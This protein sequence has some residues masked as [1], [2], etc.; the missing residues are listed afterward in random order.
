MGNQQGRGLPWAD[1]GSGLLWH[2][3]CP[4][5]LPGLCSQRSLRPHRPLPQLCLTSPSRAAPVSSGGLPSSQCRPS[6]SCALRNGSCPCHPTRGLT[7]SRSGGERGR[8]HAGA[9][10]AQPCLP[11]PLLSPPL[12]SWGFLLGEEEGEGPEAGA[13]GQPSG[14]AFR[15]S[16]SRGSSWPGEELKALG[17]AGASAERAREAASRRSPSMLPLLGHTLFPPPPRP[18]HKAFPRT[19]RPRAGEPGSPLWGQGREGGAARGSGG[20]PGRCKGGLPPV[21]G[22]GGP[23]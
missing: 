12:L 16:G 17:R 14:K 21:S 15:R 7:L 13:G 5:P 10:P 1:H 18:G 8:V 19:L 3:P 4:H 23:G 22:T 6:C 11:A 2:T 9:D 20:R